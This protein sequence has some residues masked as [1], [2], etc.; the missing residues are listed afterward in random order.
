MRTLYVQAD[1]GISGD[2][3]LGML[4]DL[5]VD[6]GTL[7]TELNKL[8]LSG[9][10]LTFE[11][12]V[13]S[14]VR[15]C[16]ARVLAEEKQPHRHLGQIRQ[17]ITGSELSPEIKSQAI[18]IFTLLAESEARVHGMDVEKVHFH[19]VGAIDAMVDIVGSVIGLS[20]LNVDRVIV[21]PLHVGS[22]TVACTHG[23][24]SIPAPATA[25]LLVGVPIYSTG[26]EGE[27]VTPTGAALVMGLATNF[28]PLPAM[29]I[30][31]VGYGA[32]ERDF[33]QANVL[34][35]MLGEEIA[36]QEACPGQAYPRLHRGKAMVIE[37]NVDD[38]Q[39][40]ILGYTMEK[41]LAAGALDVYFTPIQMKKGRPATLLH[42]VTLEERAHELIKIV[43]EETSTI[44]ARCYG[45]DKLMLYRESIEVQTPWGA[46]RA[47]VSYLD[48]VP[49]TL[50]PEYEDCKQL[51]M[52]VSVPLRD[53]YRVVEEA[54][55][56][57]LNLK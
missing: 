14:G 30:Q 12:V 3:F 38:T 25:D 41:L 7:R 51:A 24:I 4:V 9:F 19:E 45:V 18:K 28:G 23:I 1:M 31:R 34:R 20:M 57:Q 36:S 13:K 47:K 2:M 17:I 44:G 53:V 11:T 55:R 33:S 5:G 27:L 35:G 46:A 6:P 32:G 15:A 22:G 26:L 48:G 43:F 21:S 37:T 40:E 49:V 54:V 50:A 16:K 10:E 29:T 39:P 52:S 56:K 8:P 42:I